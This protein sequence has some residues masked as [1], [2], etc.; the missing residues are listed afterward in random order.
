[1]SVPS[2]GA[3]NG[4]RLEDAHKLLQAQVDLLNK[5]GI[6]KYLSTDWK[7]TPLIKILNQFR[8]FS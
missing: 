8:L 6:E 5:Y 4:M 2:L 7:I 1:M 3:Q